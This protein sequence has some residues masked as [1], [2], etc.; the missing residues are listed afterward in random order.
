MPRRAAHPPV[1]RINIAVV[2][3]A[4]RRPATSDASYYILERGKTLVCL[5][6]RK[7]LVQIGSVTGASGIRSRTCRRT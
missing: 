6:V 7:T 3:Q 5:R 2:Q 4:F 1:P